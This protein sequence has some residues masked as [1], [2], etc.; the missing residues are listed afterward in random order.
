MDIRRGPVVSVQTLGFRPTCTCSTYP[1]DTSYG[2]PNDVGE[3]E[4]VPF[5]PIPATVLDPFVGS[6]TTLQVARALGRHGIGLD[7][8]YS[9]LHDQARE[10]LGLAALD[11]WGQESIDG[12]NGCS[13]EELPLFA[14]VSL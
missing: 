10:R 13:V 9:Y 8:S 12:G 14:G 5:D 1:P 3:L 4:G 6:G 11:A 7:L 2:G